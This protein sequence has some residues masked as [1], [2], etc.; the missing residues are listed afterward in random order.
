MSVQS[1]DFLLHMN[2]CRKQ[3]SGFLQNLK[4]MYEYT[5]MADLGKQLFVPQ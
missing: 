2:I 1:L 5:G 4:T 3:F